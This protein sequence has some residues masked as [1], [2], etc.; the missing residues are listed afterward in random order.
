MSDTLQAGTTA[1]DFD[2]FMAAGRSPTT[3]DGRGRRTGWWTSPRR[4]E[5]PS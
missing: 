3:A 1:R 2:F 4:R 5:A